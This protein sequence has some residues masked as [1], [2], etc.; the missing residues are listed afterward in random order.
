[1]GYKKGQKEYG[2]QWFFTEVDFDD[3][4]TMGNSS[5]LLRGI[6]SY[7][8]GDSGHMSMANGDGILRTAVYEDDRKSLSKL[9]EVRAQQIEA[10]QEDLENCMRPGMSPTK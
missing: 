4:K 2:L 1:V 10:L 8:I 7:A 3:R 6:G 5:A 9:K